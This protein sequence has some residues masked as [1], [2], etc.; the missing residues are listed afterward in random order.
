MEKMNG[1]IIE[2]GIVIAKIN[3]TYR[4]RSITRDGI[5][6]PLLK[7]AEN[8]LSVADK[9]YFFLFPDGDG[10]IIAKM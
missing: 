4:V 5:I 10:M 8:T 7:S 3:D 1:A 9:V 2:R 6:T